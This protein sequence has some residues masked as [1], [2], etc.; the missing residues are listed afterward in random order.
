M[1][2]NLVPAL[3]C[4]PT[5]LNQA[6]YTTTELETALGAVLELVAVVGLGLGN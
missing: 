6:L 2:A 1:I 4:A 3:L 5:S